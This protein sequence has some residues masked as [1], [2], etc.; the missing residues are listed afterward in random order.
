MFVFHR[1]SLS[2]C[3]STCLTLSFTVCLPVSF[4]WLLFIYFSCPNISCLSFSLP[5]SLSLFLILAL[6]LWFSHSVTLFYF[7]CLW[8]TPCLF[9]VLFPSSSLSLIFFSICLM[10]NYCPQPCSSQKQKQGSVI[11]V[12]I[13]RNYGIQ[14]GNI[15]IQLLNLSLI[16][17][18]MYLLY[19]KVFFKSARI[20]FLEKKFI[21]WSKIKTLLNTRVESLIL[22][23]PRD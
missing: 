22:C 20:F 7:V 2:L 9:R 13:S 18:H 14:H 12:T 17:T 21:T 15:T 8:L 4:S 11:K 3:V 5:H 10:F 19:P 23:F 1:L 16:H 6:F